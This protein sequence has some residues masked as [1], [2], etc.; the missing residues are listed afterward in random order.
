MNRHFA[1]ISKARRLFDYDP[2]IDLATGL[3][4]TAD[5]FRKNEILER[6]GGENAGSPN[7]DRQTGTA[8]RGSLNGD[9]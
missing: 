7:W 1:D 2:K 6:V 8:E 9:R 4:R 5:W 3:Q